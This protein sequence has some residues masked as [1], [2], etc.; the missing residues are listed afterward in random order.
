MPLKLHRLTIFSNTCHRLAVELELQLQAHQGRSSHHKG[1]TKGLSN[2]GH[3]PAS[4][5]GIS[6]GKDVPMC[7]GKDKKWYPA[8]VFLCAYM[9]Q[10]QQDAMFSSRGKHETA[11]AAARLLPESEALTTTILCGP[12]P[13]SLCPSSHNSAAEKSSDWSPESPA[14]TTPLQP[15]QLRPFAAQLAAFDSAWCSYLYHFVAWEVKDAQVLEADLTQMACQNSLCCRNAKF[16]LME[17]HLD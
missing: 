6:M 2:G 9:I 14:S 7:E 4:G 8:H 11:L 16:Y 5:A 12:L 15:P 17:I 3:C 1:D 10:E 13:T